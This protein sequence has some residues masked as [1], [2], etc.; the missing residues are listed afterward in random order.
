[1]LFFFIQQVF[2]VLVDKMGWVEVE[3]FV[4]DFEAGKFEHL[5]HY[6]WYWF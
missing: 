1:M 4:V 2:R 5:L 6:I 3:G